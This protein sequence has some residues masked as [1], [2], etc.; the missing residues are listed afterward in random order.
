[1]NESSR[2]L[3]EAITMVPV[4]VVHAYNRH[5]ALMPLC[6]MMH[7]FLSFSMHMSKYTGTNDTLSTLLLISDKIGIL[8]VVWSGHTAIQ[9]PK[10]RRFVVPLIVNGVCIY[11]GQWY[12]E[13]L[14]V[15][16]YDVPLFIYAGIVVLEYVRL[17]RRR[18]LLL[19][20]VFI[21]TAG[22]LSRVT[23]LLHIMLIP[24]FCIWYGVINERMSY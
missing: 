12:Y 4:F 21:G 7:A 16:W 15:A 11:R 24:S 9:R 10:A 5:C 13:H 17:Y 3:V 19:L 20:W 6:G 2:Q 14:V 18:A 1:M 23:G 8:G 22:H